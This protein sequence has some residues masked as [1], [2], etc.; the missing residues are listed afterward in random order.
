M[1]AL[2]ETLGFE[3]AIVEGARAT[4]RGLLQAYDALIERTNA[5]DQII[6]YYSG[7]GG[8]ALGAEPELGRG[9][10]ADRQ[11]LIPIDFHESAENDF[12][13]ILDLELSERLDRLTAR[14]TNVVVILDCCHAASLSRS[15]QLVS[16][17]YTGPVPP[18]LRAHARRWRDENAKT[19]RRLDHARAIRLVAT[20]RDRLA[21]ETPGSDGLVRGIFT[22]ALERVLKEA[23][24][25]SFLTWARVARAVREDVLRIAPEQRV[26]VEGPAQ[27]CLFS[28]VEETENVPAFFLD[29]VLPA[30]RAGRLHGIDERSVFSIMPYGAQADEPTRRLATAEVIEAF[31]DRA[32]VSLSTKISP[33]NGAPAFLLSSRLGRRAVAID[34]LNSMRDRIAAQ[35]ALGPYLRVVDRAEDPSVIA[36]LREVGGQQLI[37]WPAP[38]DIYVRQPYPRGTSAAVIA[39][40][41]TLLA[42]ADRLRA[43]D[44][45][46]L[47]AELDL[48][49]GTVEASG[50]TTLPH[51]NTKIHA[52]DRIWLS[53]ENSFSK[54]L[55]VGVLD[56][57]ITGRISLIH[58]EMLGVRL[59][60]GAVKTFGASIGGRI[61]GLPIYWPELVPTDQ[62]PRN[63]NLVI[64][65][66][67]RF[68]DFSLFEQKG[69]RA[70]TKDILE[71]NHSQYSVFH[72]DF[73]LEPPA[74]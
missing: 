60:P 48:R 41:L 30:V 40:D 54:M 62:G 52:A 51:C 72:I 3:L 39:E 17:G 36:R 32:H 55:Y 46:A 34:P 35:L 12:R 65:A 2:F 1:R 58:A 43:L 9:D 6:I 49:W 42:K 37:L 7:H 47:A 71:P 50:P 4:R 53:V 28:E 59:E 61:E 68:L 25:E 44:D 14:T 15:P 74:R 22:R 64:I 67:D 27:R 5:G 63:E 24:A 45:G 13:G 16:R 66:S 73:L 11:Y 21:Y 33:P 23:G 56:I 8:I 10:L 19:S 26:A 20:E 70:P 18:A 69:L 29:G 57:G 38:D 31:A